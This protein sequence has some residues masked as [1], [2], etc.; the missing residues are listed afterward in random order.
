MNPQ[1]C[2]KTVKK[3]MGYALIALG[4]WLN[5]GG[6]APVDPP[7]LVPDA[8]AS[9]CEAAEDNLARL[10]CPLKPGHCA[11]F[12]ADLPGLLDTGCLVEAQDCSE[13]MACDADSQR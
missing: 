10:G 2:W 7:V 6:C 9:M 12:E 5:G 13:A 3:A 1:M 8:G 11:Q 4:A